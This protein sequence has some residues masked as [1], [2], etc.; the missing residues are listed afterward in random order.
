[1]S[2]LLIKSNWKVSSFS[3]LLTRQN[4]AAVHDDPDLKTLRGGFNVSNKT[5]EL[6][7]AARFLDQ[8]SVVNALNL[9]GLPEGITNFHDL[10]IYLK[11]KKTNNASSK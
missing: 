5:P 10:I 8:L 7:K 1:M 9:V 11:R 2:N 6:I 3:D 4:L